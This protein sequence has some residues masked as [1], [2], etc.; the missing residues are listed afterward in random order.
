[1]SKERS[2]YCYLVIFDGTYR[3]G[4]LGSGRFLSRK[5]SFPAKETTVPRIGNSRSPL[6][7]REFPMRENFRLLNINLL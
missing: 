5:S 4:L 1:M 2:I 7:E 3:R 6:W